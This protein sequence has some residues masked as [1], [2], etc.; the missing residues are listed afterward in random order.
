[1]ATIKEIA[2]EAG[3]SPSTVSIVLGGKSVERKIS[4]GTQE[5]ILAIAKQRG[6]RVN[7]AARG[8]W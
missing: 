2:K 8:R 4:E 7:I 3:V 5:K 6:Y 1:M